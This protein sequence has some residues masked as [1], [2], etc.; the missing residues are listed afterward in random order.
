MIQLESKIFK[1]RYE[2]RTLGTQLSDEV[3]DTENDQYL[4]R[5][6]LNSQRAESI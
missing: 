6:S 2:A 4:M 3:V 1:E 5:Y